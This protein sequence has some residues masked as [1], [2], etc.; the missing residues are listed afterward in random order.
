MKRFGIIVLIAFVYFTLP[1]QIFAEGVTPGW[2]TYDGLGPCEGGVALDGE[3]CRIDGDLVNPTFSPNTLTKPCSFDNIKEILSCVASQVHTRV[4]TFTWS[5]K[6]AA[7]NFDLN[8]LNA[9]LEGARLPLTPKLVWDV[10]K[11]N[12]NPQSDSWIARACDIKKQNDEPA[13]EIR[14]EVS[15]EIMKLG[16]DDNIK[17][18]VENLEYYKSAYVTLKKSDQNYQ[19]ASETVQPGTAYGCNYTKEAIHVGQS[20]KESQG[21]GIWD[22]LKIVFNTIWFSLEAKNK[23][24]KV[25]TETARKPFSEE[26]AGG[27]VQVNEEILSDSRVSDTRKSAV[28]AT[29]GLVETFRPC[30]LKFEG[31]DRH[32]E[33]NNEYEW[34][35]GGTFGIKSR[36]HLMKLVDESTI[37]LQSSLLPALKQEEKQKKIN[38]SR[39][40]EYEASTLNPI[41]PSN[42]ITSSLKHP[43]QI[44][45]LSC[46]AT[47]ES[48]KM[49][50][51]ASKDLNGAISEAAAWGNIDSCILN[52]VAEAESAKNEIASGQCMPNECGAAG[53]FQITTG[54]TLNGSGSQCSKGD[55]S[56][57]GSLTTCPNALKD[58]GFQSYKPLLD[59]VCGKGESCQLNPC[60]TKHATFIATSMLI[61]KAS[62]FKQS[63]QGNISDPAVQQAIVTA[64]DS[65]FGTPRAL[66]EYERFKGLSYG[67]FVLSHCVATTHKEHTWPNANPTL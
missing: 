33:V 9:M 35:G 37:F 17:R 53:P 13:E 45:P 64:G 5:S 6:K 23:S 3:S 47:M 8:D 31:P 55:C 24:E 48:E 67:E 14:N 32:G 56:K 59:A 15:K 22:I 11:R 66:T 27:M 44:K 36:Q 30:T 46:N 21:K 58:F 57:C 54:F 41:S 61:G 52:G 25:I 20:V 28:M 40:C 7:A 39:P 10:T 60:D 63:I 16:P 43:G 12:T 1:R 4:D 62:Y 19:K 26:M 34:D 38:D 29:A 50:R 42:E 65:Y 18:T 51:N 2:G 49:S